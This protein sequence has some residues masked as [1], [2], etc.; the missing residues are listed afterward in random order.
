MNLPN[1]HHLVVFGSLFILYSFFFIHNYHTTLSSLLYHGSVED[2]ISAKVASDLTA[3]CRSTKWTPGLW[4]HCHSSCR[5]NL[6]S[7]CGGLNNARHR[8]Q[9]CIRLAIDGG[10][11]VVLSTVT[12][13]DGM[14]LGSRIRAISCVQRNGGILRS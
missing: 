9:S 5:P 12:N 13:R 11:G 2:E 10:A 4:L 6:N 3:V 14:I 7:L 8:F 1:P